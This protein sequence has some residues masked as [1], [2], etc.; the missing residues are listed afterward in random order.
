MILLGLTGP[1]ACG[2]TTV[3]RLLEARGAKVIDADALVHE[4]MAPGQAVW[5]SIVTEFGQQILHP[6]KTIDRK[7]LGARVFS[8]KEAMRRLERIVHP[9]TIAEI[10]DRLRSFRNE[11]VPHSQN[12]VV[13]LEAIKLIEG[14]YHRRCHAV[15]IVTCDPNRQIERLMTVRNL[16]REDAETRLRAQAGWS[17]KMRYADV[18]IRNDGTRKQLEAAVDAAWSRL[19][20]Q[21]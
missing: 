10:E 20:A 18:I 8:D 12:A 13:V 14:G 5:H 3:L 7:R 19:L 17:D 4:L 2:K 9:A 1:I 15:W 6:D 21:D 11:K 16:S